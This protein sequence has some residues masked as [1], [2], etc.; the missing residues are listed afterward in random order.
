[1]TDEPAHANPRRIWFFFGLKDR[2]PLSADGWTLFEHQR[3]CMGENDEGLACMA[4]Q[5]PCV[6]KYVRFSGTATVDTTTFIGMHDAS[7]LVEE[8]NGGDPDSVP[9]PP[10]TGMADYRWAVAVS[11][12][13][14]GDEQPSFNEAFDVVVDAVIALRNATQRSI[15]DPAVE[16]LTPMYL[17]GWEK[18]EGRVE[19][20]Q[21]VIVEH[22]VPGPPPPASPQEMSAASELFVA[23]RNHDP[24]EQYRTFAT[25]ARCAL[26][27]GDYTN[28]IL[29]AAI[30]SE[31]LIKNAAWMITFEATLLD[32]DP[33]PLPL[34]SDVTDLKPR[35]LIG[36]VLQPRLGGNWSSTHPGQPVHEWRFGI[37][38]LRNDLLHLGGHVGGAEAD[39]A[40]HALDLLEAAV[41]DRIA[42]QAAAYPRSAFTLLGPAALDH[43]GVLPV[44][45]QA[46]DSLTG[47]R[48]SFVAEFRSFLA[49][50][51][52]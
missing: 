42:G 36:Q 41:C 47:D 46:L 10:D 22:V 37:A 49:P 34:A 28:T 3:G 2:L 40:V 31:L 48:A 23:R 19:P 27:D 7:R 13:M 16:R 1:M 12:T 20:T 52:A 30:A 25:R 6:A 24:V 21:I 26:S 51:L 35:Q 15:P 32:R 44:V 29:H 45:E 38:K 39:R 50:L 9:P 8:I 11:L 17:I 5:V 33:S 43:R 4:G 18:D 14:D